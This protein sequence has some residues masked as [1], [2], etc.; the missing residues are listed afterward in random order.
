MADYS[1]RVRIQEDTTPALQELAADLGFIATRPGKFL[2]APSP[3]SLLDALAAAYR[4]DPYRVT[5]ALEEI[6]IYNKDD[7]P[8]DAVEPVE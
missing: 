8:A 7:P 1:Y 5:N 6:G 2:G 3:G 4:A